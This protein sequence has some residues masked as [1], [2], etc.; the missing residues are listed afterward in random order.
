MPK[1]YK[2]EF[3]FIFDVAIIN[4]FILCKHFTDLGPYDLKS[5][6]TELAK[7][8]I[9]SYCSRKRPGRPSQSAPPPK[10]FCSSHFPVRGSE[11]QRRCHYC[12][13]YRN[14]RHGT[15]WYCNECKLF[16]CHNGKDDDCFLQYHK[17]Y[18]P[19]TTEMLIPLV[20]F[21]SHTCALTCSLN[22]PL[23]SFVAVHRHLTLFTYFHCTVFTLVLLYDYNLCHV[24]MPIT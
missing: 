24:H 1:I 11:K 4:S 22:S 18:V 21:R 9:G 13:K 10:R 19:S 7:S 5:F 20:I 2:Y 15:L 17:R 12:S 14:E 3:W 8:L 6:R 16:L 23:T